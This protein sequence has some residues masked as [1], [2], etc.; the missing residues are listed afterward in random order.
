MT[1]TKCYKIIKKKEKPSALWT[2]SGPQLILLSFNT[3]PHKF[4]EED[5]EIN[6]DI[7]IVSMLWNSD[8]SVAY[9]NR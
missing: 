7:M 3:R 4:H 8:V 5:D 1:N 9:I 2:G 6:C